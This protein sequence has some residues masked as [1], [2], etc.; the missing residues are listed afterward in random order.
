MSR[1]YTL[2][3]G[4]ARLTIKVKPG[5]KHQIKP[6]IVDIGDGKEAL[7]IS[8][9]AR[10]QDGKANQEVCRMLA[11]FLCV[12]PKDITLK[13]GHKSRIKIV[14]IKGCDDKNFFSFLS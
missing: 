10:P 8:V 13:T 6:H 12:S 5:A 1:F 2:L 9:R 3:N 4:S 14:E 7:E 11:T